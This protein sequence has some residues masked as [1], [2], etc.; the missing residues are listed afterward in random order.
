MKV[1]VV[2]LVCCVIVM[3]FGAVVS[4]EE[5]EENYVDLKKRHEECLTYIDDLSMQSEDAQCLEGAADLYEML[6]ECEERLK[7]HND[8]AHR[9]ELR[10]LICETADKLEVKD[11]QLWKNKNR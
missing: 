8:W 6:D 10:L 2:L 3:M 9:C 1:P 4:L 11:G 5:N 7:F